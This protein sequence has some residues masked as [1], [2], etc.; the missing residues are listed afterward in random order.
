MVKKSVIWHF[1][2][3]K[4]ATNGFSWLKSQSWEFYQTV[5]LSMCQRKSN[6]KSHSVIHSFGLNYYFS[7]LHKKNKKTVSTRNPKEKWYCHFYRSNSSKSKYLRCTVYS[8]QTWREQVECHSKCNWMHS[9]FLDQSQQLNNHSK[10]NKNLFESTQENKR[11]NNV[12]QDV[13]F[14]YQL[15]WNW[16]KNEKK[17]AP[18]IIT[19]AFE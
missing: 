2:D 17:T 5:N 15:L 13:L 7:T 9:Q 19:H 16:N 1:V 4:Q 8:V 12:A 6:T 10:L 3:W 18:K 11:K 14:T